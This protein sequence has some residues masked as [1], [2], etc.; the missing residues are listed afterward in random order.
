MSLEPSSAPLDPNRLKD[1]APPGVRIE[2][3]EQTESTNADV[4]GR[5]KAGE[6]DGLV[7]AAD[8]Q[9]AGRGRLDR[10]WVTPAGTAVTF[11]MLLRPSAPAARWPWLPLVAGV[12]VVRAL[13][14]TWGKPELKWPND[15]LLRGRKVAGI[16]VELTETP[17]GPAAVLG[18]GLNTGLTDDQLPVPDATSLLIESGTAPD[19]TEVLL[20]LVRELS[21]AFEGWPSA[22]LEEAY[23]EAC[24]TLGR[25]VRVEMPDGSLLEGKASEIDPTGRLVVETEEGPQA[26][27][28][29]DVVHVRPSS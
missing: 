22:E 9:T 21:A 5:A 4:A 2:V 14:E 11:S 1:G 20:D 10:T 23:R 19:R 25:E 17:D 24:S 29:G 28:A 8:D 26:V 7:V 13:G 15:V 16:L 12:A 6:A 3:V 18:V 27:G